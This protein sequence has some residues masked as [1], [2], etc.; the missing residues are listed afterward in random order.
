MARG[1]RKPPP[2]GEVARLIHEYLGPRSYAWVSREIDKRWGDKGVSR[3]PEAV[4]FCCQGR[5]GHNSGYVH[6]GMRSVSRITKGKKTSEPSTLWLVADVLGIPWDE[7]TSAL[8]RDIM[9]E[10]DAL[11]WDQAPSMGYFLH[12]A[13]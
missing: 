1:R 12:L 10:I 4:R 13:V 2:D 8:Q 3:T 5:A 9:R 7:I 6:R 11:D